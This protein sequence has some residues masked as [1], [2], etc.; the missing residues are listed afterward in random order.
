MRKERRDNCYVFNS[1]R[2]KLSFTQ[3]KMQ[4]IHFKKKCTKHTDLTYPG[5]LKILGYQALFLSL[6]N[7]HFI[8]E[9]FKLINW[10]IAF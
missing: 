9:K 6:F 5:A 7:I 10:L 8:M 3:Y 2:V 4:M 1:V